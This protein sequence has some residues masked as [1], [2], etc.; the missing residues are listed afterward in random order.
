MDI[1]KLIYKNQIKIS[2]KF[3]FFISSEKKKSPCKFIV[4]DQ[5]PEVL[6]KAKNNGGEKPSSPR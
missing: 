2:N 6:K 5:D 3:F 4:S 1:L